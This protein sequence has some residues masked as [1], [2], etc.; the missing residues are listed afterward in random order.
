MKNKGKITCQ[1]PK[2]NS[3]LPDKLG[4]SLSEIDDI[5]WL[6]KATETLWQLLDNIDTADDMAK[7]NCNFYRALVQ[8]EMEKRFN[9]LISDGYNLFLP[10]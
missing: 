3:E 4:K 1:M 9:I 7:E 10:K 8:K 5:A 2:Y 6:R